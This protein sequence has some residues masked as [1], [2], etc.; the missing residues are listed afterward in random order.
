MSLPVYQIECSWE[1]A[2]FADPLLQN[3]SREQ[4]GSQKQSSAN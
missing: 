3:V 2:A 1:F 4:A